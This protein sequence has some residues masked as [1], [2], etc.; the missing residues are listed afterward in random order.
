MLNKNIL[1]RN[2]ALVGGSSDIGNEIIRQLNLQTLENLYIFGRDNSIVNDYEKKGINVNF[3][4]I[5]VEKINF[6]KKL[7][8]ILG[9]IEKI[10]FLIMALGYLPPE[11]Q[12]LESNFVQKSMLV[13]AVGGTVVLS[14][15]VN[16]ML[17]QEFGKLLYISSVASMRPRLKNFTYGASKKAADF[18]VDGLQSKYKNTNL[19]IY[20]L[21][22][23]FVFTKLSRDFKPAP[24]AIHPN[25]VAK[26]ALK[27]IKKNKKVIYAPK[28]LLLIMNIVVMLPRAIFNRLE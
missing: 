24:F 22:P 11:N 14:C 20:I 27:G 28:I 13:N 23:G 21:R 25:K 5:D 16:K 19:N 10:D 18:F 4:E 9:S 8:E 1:F 6:E 3:F 12:D 7:L 15:F 17:N 2:V 26:L